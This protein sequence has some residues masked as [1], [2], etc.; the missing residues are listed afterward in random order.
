MAV[1]YQIFTN[2]IEKLKTQVPSLTQ[3]DIVTTL[4]IIYMSC[5]KYDYVADSVDYITLYYKKTI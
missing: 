2:I 3:E 4:D 5:T 1:A